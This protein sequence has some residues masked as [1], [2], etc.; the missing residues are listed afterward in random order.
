MLH[1]TPRMRCAALT[2]GWAISAQ[3][4][5]SLNNALLLSPGQRTSNPH[6]CYFGQF[7]NVQH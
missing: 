5:T 2:K 4:K 3:Q 1:F 6:S 7:F